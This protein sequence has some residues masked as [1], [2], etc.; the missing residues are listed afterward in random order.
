MRTVGIARAN[1]HVRAARGLLLAGHSSA[2]AV[3]EAGEVVAAANACHDKEKNETSEKK[4][5]CYR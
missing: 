3:A 5:C 2:T 1:A 4:S